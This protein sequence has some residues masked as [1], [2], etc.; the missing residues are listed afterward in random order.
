MKRWLGTTLLLGLLSACD[1]ASVK[2]APSTIAR[3]QCQN[4]EDCDTGLCG[5]DQQCRS[6]TPTL[7][8][9]LF[10]VTPPAD[11]SP[12]GGA[13]FLL[14]N[15]DL[16]EGSANLVL[17]QISQV[18]GKVTA[19]KFK[20][21]PRFGQAGDV[22]VM[23]NDLSVPAQVSLTPTTGALGLYSPRAVVQAALREDKYF[24]YSVNVPPGYYDIYVQPNQQPDQSC[25]APPLLLRGQQVK[26]GTSTLDFEL[27]APSAFEFHVTWPRGDGALEGWTVDMLD[28]ESG[29]TISNRVQ[30]AL[31]EGSTTNYHATLSYNRVLIVNPAG[32]QPGDQL[33]RL[34]PPDG[35]PESAAAPT[36]LM[37]RSALALFDAD[38][39][40]LTDFTTLPEPV[41]V[42]GQ[43]TVEDSPRPVAATVTLVATEITGIDSGVL[44]SFVRNVSVGAN[45]TF[46]VHLL[47]GKYRVST[48]PQAPLD[49]SMLEM[50]PLGADIRTWTVPSSP[51][52]QQGKVIGLSKALSV[53]G[54]VVDASGD[55][56]AAAQ[57]QAS[58]SPLPVTPSNFLRE[59]LAGSAFVP[60]ASA[61]RVTGNGDFDLKTD[62]GT[63]DFSVR[64]DSDTGFSWLVMPRVSVLPSA[65][66]YLGLISMPL[67]VPYRGTVTIADT[68]DVVPGALV[69]AYAYLKDGE[70]TSNER[71]DAD[72]VLQVAETRSDKNGEF[73]IFIPAELNHAPDHAAE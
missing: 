18:T 57:V 41:H 2:E 10:E 26:K 73:T 68:P 64:P 7:Q 8:N 21:M 53:T 45:G 56:V 55:A 31:D 33:L 35:L 50:A 69:R 71:S 23:A 32:A 20:C 61:G 5:S 15:N 3:N 44:T 66:K 49:L 24:G 65:G 25:P 39:G 67:P 51:S 47:P 40:T 48:V 46:D 36:V 29:R 59:S 28:P 17:E 43:V 12:I 6:R 1:V 30:L 22:L 16:S 27:P 63:F 72:S 4:N 54:R 14:L 42:V 38:S 62:V 37:A 13:Q 60:R 19:A 11:G 34:S 58:A 9:V 52:E 70:Y